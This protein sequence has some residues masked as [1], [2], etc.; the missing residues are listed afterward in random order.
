MEAG[1]VS[2][3]DTAFGVESQASDRFS[4]SDF[5][6]SE[7]RKIYSGKNK[8]IRKAHTFRILRKTMRIIHRRRQLRQPGRIP[9]LLRKERFRHRS[10]VVSRRLLHHCRHHVRKNQAPFRDKRHNRCT[11][12]RRRI[13]RERIPRFYLRYLP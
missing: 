13:F 7:N 1:F 2:L 4:R 5:R 12:Y 6:S 10:S 8:K 11:D 3:H 9:W